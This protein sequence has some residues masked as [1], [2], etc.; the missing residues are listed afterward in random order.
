[1]NTDNTTTSDHTW[2]KKGVEVLLYNDDGREDRG[3]K[4]TTIDKVT[5]HTFTVS[6]E[7]EPRFRFKLKNRI[8][9]SYFVRC[10]GD[11]GYRRIVV[12][13]DSDKARDEL[14]RLEIRRLNVGAKAAVD[15]WLRSRVRADRLRAIEA[16]QALEGHDE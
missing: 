5:E 11:W 10:G 15:L 6:D 7:S 14:K 3:V 4:K 1:M 12:P 13:L 8:D 9:G 16:L 2:V